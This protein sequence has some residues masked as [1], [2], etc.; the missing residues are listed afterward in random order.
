MMYYRNDWMVG[1]MIGGVILLALIILV[2]YLLVRTYRKPGS[3]KDAGYSGY[4]RNSGAETDPAARALG[5][6]AERYAKG[7]ITD[8][9]YRQKKSE[10]MKP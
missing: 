8:E 6:L 10:I 7:E 9:E 1:M 2:I 3:G 4:S 5:I